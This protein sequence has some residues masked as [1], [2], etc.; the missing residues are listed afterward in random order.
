MVL[1]GMTIPLFN[2]PSMVLLQEKVSADMQG[3]VFGLIQIVSS[4]IMPLGLLVYGPLAD[5]IRI[6]TLMIVTGALMVL[7]SIGMLYNKNFI[8]EGVKAA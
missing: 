5:I 2:S 3:R 7:L 6:E 8:R 1:T 4:G